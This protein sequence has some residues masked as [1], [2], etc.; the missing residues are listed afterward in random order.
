MKRPVPTLSESPFGFDEFFFST[1]N[2]RGVIASGNDIFVRVSGYPREKILGAP[3]SLIRH[4]DMPRAVFK[5]LWD[6]IQSGKSIGAYVKNMAS[7]GSYYWVF[8]FV[9]PIDQG[10]LSIRFKPSSP[11]FNTVEELYKEI[12]EFEKEN[13]DLEKSVELLVRKIQ[14]KGFSSYDEFMVQAA[15]TELEAREEKVKEQEQAKASILGDYKERQKVEAISEVSKVALEN[16]ADA[17][18]RI[19]DFQTSRQIFEK[20]IEDL[21]AGFNHL[22]YIS[23]NMTIS[24]AKF[25]TVAA[26]LGVV[27]KEFSELSGQIEEHFKG[28]SDFIQMLSSVIQQCA[29]RISALHVQMLMVD[30][31]VKE[32]IAKLRISDNAFAQ[33][34]ETQADFA[35]LFKDYAIEFQNEITSLT[36]NLK[37]IQ[38]KFDEV[39]KFITGLEVIKQIGAVESARV[40]DVKVTFIHYLEEMDRFIALLRKSTTEIRSQADQLSTHVRT[41]SESSETLSASVDQIFSLAADLA[42]QIV[43]GTAANYR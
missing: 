22:K 39:R 2:K 15:L 8:A 43:E 29:F 37:E 23:F 32:S 31:F 36:S 5:V 9:F 40:D 10:Y 41:I 7:N 4:P 21:G 25:G 6:F 33:M 13:G 28:L 42:P 12:L 18:H 14:E 30:F 27:S 16:L 24:A 3:H 17:F 1:T 34:H 26:S 11:I 35:K 19:Q 20:T 38:S